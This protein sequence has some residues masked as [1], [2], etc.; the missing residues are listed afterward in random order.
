[1]ERTLVLIKPDGM[2][3]NLADE[4]ISRY[5]DAG[6]NIVAKKTVEVSRELAENHYP[7]SDSQVVGMGNKTI[8]AAEEAGNPDSVMELFGT[9]DPREIGMM[10]R[11]WLVEFI[12]S[13]P[14]IAIILEG[15]GAIQHVRKL[16]GFT[17]PSRAEK[18]TIRGD[19]GEDS[20]QK[21]N[22]E[23]RATENLVHASGNPEEAAAEIALWF[24][25]EELE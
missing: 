16:T 6:L 9:K 14:V 20:I 19:L 23:K 10:L 2:R 13:V 21:A 5:I 3:R 12:M 7:A 18:G 17:D 22:S 11:E 24:T 1:M 4:I 8:Q 25:E 15:D